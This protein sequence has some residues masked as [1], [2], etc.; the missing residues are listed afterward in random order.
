MMQKYLIAF[1]L[2]FLVFTFSCKQDYTPKPHGYFRIDFQQKSYHMLD[3]AGLPYNFEIPGYGKVV[4]DDERIA[5]AFWVNLKIP[6]HKAELNLS[7]KK[8]ENNLEQLTEDSRKLAYKHDVKA[9]AINEKIFVNPAKKVY[10][11]IYLIDGNAASPLQFYLTD[12]T[13][14]FLRGALYIREVPNIDSLRPV[15]DFLTPDIIH[16]IETTEWKN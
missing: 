1:P 13:K 6:A 4:P 14:N 2:L 15:I 9:D 16:L 10:G 3:S 11:T 8:I 7:Y 12:S 5:E